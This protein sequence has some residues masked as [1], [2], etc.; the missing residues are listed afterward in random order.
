MGLQPAAARRG[1]PLLLLISVAATIHASAPAAAFDFFGLFGARETP[2]APSRD[3]LP[4]T[5]AFEGAEDRDLKQ[6]LQSTSTLYRLRQEPPPDGDSLL[7]RV[8]DRPAPPH[9][10]R[11]GR[12]LLRWPGFHPD[13]PRRRRD[14]THTAAGSRPPGRELSR[15]RAGAD[16]RRR[17][18]GAAVQGAHRHRAR[19]PHRPAVRSAGTAAAPSRQGRGERCRFGDRPRGGGAHHRPLP[20]WR[21]SLREGRA[22]RSGRRSPQQHPRRFLRRRSWPEGQSRRHC[23][24]RHRERATRRWCAP[25][26]MPRPATLIRRR[27]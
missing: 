3:A 18:A 17:R 2:P 20:Q 15:P 8:R 7:R 14:R 13:R 1:R 23:R 27:R 11:L 22:P 9:R 19:R 24:A 4:Y 6:A 16:P 5:V 25:S 21:P 10:R 12:R 26:S